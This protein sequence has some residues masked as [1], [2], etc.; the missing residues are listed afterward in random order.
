MKVTSRFASFPL[1]PSRSSTQRKTD[2]TNTVNVARPSAHRK[3]RNRNVCLSSTNPATRL[4][5]SSDALVTLHVNSAHRMEKIPRLETCQLTPASMILIPSLLVTSSSVME[6][7]A[8][9][10]AWR[11]RAMTSRIMKR[12]V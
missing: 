4:R 8:P 6:A 3:L 1:K 7:I 9:P 5:L 12:M 11:R 10:T 2:L